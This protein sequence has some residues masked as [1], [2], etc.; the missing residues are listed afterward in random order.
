MW[1]AVLF[2]PSILFLL[3]RPQ[4]V[5][6][7]TVAEIWLHKFLYGSRADIQRLGTILAWIVILSVYGADTIAI[8][9]SLSALI[10]WFMKSIIRFLNDPNLHAIISTLL[11]I[12]LQWVQKNLFCCIIRNI[13][14]CCPSL[15]SRFSFN[16][17]QSFNYTPYLFYKNRFK[18]EINSFC[19]WTLT[20]FDNLNLINV[21]E[22]EHPCLPGVSFRH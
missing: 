5:G 8:V 9:L 6:L 19:I 7:A 1:P 15:V 16:L 18:S 4:S 17:L 13:W 12:N 3:D 20:T 21:S 11:I 2:L 10:S 14:Q 22:P